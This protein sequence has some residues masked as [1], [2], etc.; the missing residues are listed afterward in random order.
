MCAAD[1]RPEMQRAESVHTTMLTQH[2]SQAAEPIHDALT[3]V[4][5]YVSVRLPFAVALSVAI[6]FYQRD[7][8]SGVLGDGLVYIPLSLF[9]DDGERFRIPVMEDLHEAV[10]TARMS[11]VAIEALQKALHKH[12]MG[13]I[14]LCCCGLVVG[15]RDRIE[16][17]YGSK[18]HVE[19][20]RI[21]SFFDA[22]STSISIVKSIDILRK[23]GIMSPDFSQTSYSEDRLFESIESM[24]EKAKQISPPNPDIA[25][26]QNQLTAVVERAQA[27]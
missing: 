20:D 16:E 27:A 6:D 1:K 23:E 10:L 19:R 24:L 3:A 22:E 5:S 21:R 17:F 2:M 26:M 14:F 7:N 11:E 9:A 25:I 13:V 18:D 12:D 15:Q 8:Y 4:S